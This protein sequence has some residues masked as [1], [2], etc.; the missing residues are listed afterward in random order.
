M[1]ES[2]GLH[3]FGLGH[4]G[5]HPVP[6]KLFEIETF[7]SESDITHKKSLQTT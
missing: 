5:E 6:V 1:V 7:C 3:N 4:Y 2:N